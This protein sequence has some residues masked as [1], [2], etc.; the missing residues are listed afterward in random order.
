MDLFR[1]QVKLEISEPWDAY[2]ALSGKITRLVISSEGRSY[3]L[4]QDERQAEWFVIAA[5]Y[6]NDRVEDVLLDKSIHVGIATVRDLGML[7]TDH[8]DMEQISYMGI[9]TITR[10]VNVTES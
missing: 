3:Y 2:R 4:F 5:R 9:G 8:F 1:V 7:E 6:E 10:E